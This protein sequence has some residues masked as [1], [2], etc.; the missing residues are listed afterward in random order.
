MQLHD[1]IYGAI[2]LIWGA[3][4]VKDKEHDSNELP[5]SLPIEQALFLVLERQAI[6]MESLCEQIQ[7]LTKQNQYLLE[8]VMPIQDEE[9]EE[10]EEEYM[11]L[12]Q[13][14]RPS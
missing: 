2:T 3:N 6:A 12:N 8:M 4:S 7:I 11:Y 14:Q 9:G 10:D 5:T 13:S 1:R